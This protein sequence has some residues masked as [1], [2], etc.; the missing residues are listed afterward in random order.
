MHSMPLFGHN[1]N[2]KAQISPPSG[3]N[4]DPLQSELSNTSAS[5]G[6]SSISTPKEKLKK[7]LKPKASSNDKISDDLEAKLQLSDEHPDKALRSHRLRKR[8]STIAESDVEDAHNGDSD[9]D[10][11]DSRDDYDS[12]SVDE[13]EYYEEDEHRHAI[14]IRGKSLSNHGNLAN[15]ISTIMG[16]CGIL[17]SASNESLAHLANEELKCTFSLLDSNMKISSLSSTTNKNDP[18][19]FTS[20]ICDKQVKLIEYLRN[21]L[22]ELLDLR[23]DSSIRSSYYSNS[24]TLYDRYGVVRDIIGRGSYGLIKIIDPNA[25]DATIKST[26]ISP[27]NVFYAVKEL[28]KRPG[29]ELKQK[30]T[31]AQ[32]VDR[33]LAE[34]IVSSTLNYKHIVRT[35]DLMVTI[36]TSSLIKKNMGTYAENIKI[37]Q[38]MECT[39]GGDL[40]SYL[41]TGTDKSNCPISNV[42][43]EEI[44]CFIKQITKGLWYMHQ[45]GVA[46]CDLKFENILVNYLPPDPNNPMK[47]KII[48]K[49]SDFGK[50]NV[51]RTKWDEKEQFIPYSDGPI[52]S[53][54]YIAP[55]EY[56][57]KLDMSGYYS[58][59]KKD[60]WALGIVILVLFNISKPFFFNRK[61]DDHETSDYTEGCGVFDE[62]GSGYLWHST[63]IKTHHLSKDIKYKDKVLEEYNKTRMIADYDKSTKEWLIK[64]SGTFKPIET[65]FTPPKREGVEEQVR[66]KQIDDNNAFDEDELELCELRKMFIYKLLDPNP[67]SRLT[68]EE[69]LKGDWIKAVE[70]CNV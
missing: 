63:E 13:D 34:F 35:V 28:Q 60:C 44:D 5:S 42:S 30:E 68:T 51:F 61:K 37:N 22:M 39:S 56:A 38:V 27:N 29:S 2:K 52:G 24:K 45:H 67:E 50:C 43:I 59:Q 32:F 54:R 1:K 66:D 31:K 18:N 46:H 33:V 65:L 16:Y 20:V 15:Q 41:T 12:G 69:F 4:A 47:T 26:K 7:L 62:Y 49:L 14:K 53:E 58:P 64:R 11:D 23:E 55:E 40:F 21:H 17:S 19:L 57:R 70:S 3:Q 48:L 9:Y 8:V 25:T 36:P 10:S 6:G